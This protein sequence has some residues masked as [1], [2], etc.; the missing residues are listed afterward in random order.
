[1]SWTKN[2]GECPVDGNVKVVIKV[3]CG[4]KLTAPAECFDWRLLPGNKV[5]YDI[6]KWKVSK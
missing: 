3:R 1:M 4:A 5:R 6:I 2:L